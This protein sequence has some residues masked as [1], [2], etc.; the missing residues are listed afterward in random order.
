MRQV[1]IAALTTCLV[2]ACHREGDEQRE[3]G[4]KPVNQL[5][6][7]FGGGSP[8]A[9]TGVLRA[10]VADRITQQ[11]EEA[12]TDSGQ[13]NVVFPNKVHVSINSFF[14]R[15]TSQLQSTNDEYQCMTDYTVNYMIKPDND[16]ITRIDGSFLTTSGPSDRGGM[17][18]ADPVLRSTL[19]ECNSK[20]DLYSRCQLKVIVET[21]IV[22][23]TEATTKTNVETEQRY[24]V[25]HT[26]QGPNRLVD[27]VPL[28]IDFPVLL[29]QPS[30]N[31][32]EVKCTI[33]GKPVSCHI[34]PEQVRY[35][36]S[37]S[38]NQTRLEPNSASP[39]SQ[40]N[41]M[42]PTGNVSGTGT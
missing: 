32:T 8:C 22:Y 9:D 19:D 23:P 36:N 26:E 13:S 20:R 11:A 41:T 25:L 6:G 16:R 24:V 40:V 7:I 1:I 4:L 5:S 27:G 18:L 2:A 14:L 31:A 38:P 29:G 39:D 28:L 3:G 34:T 12:I 35:A 21:P 17:F 42:T 15:N 10:A 33:G 30:R 37:I